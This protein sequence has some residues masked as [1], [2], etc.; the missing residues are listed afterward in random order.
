MNPVQL[1]ALKN[2]RYDTFDELKEH[3]NK[4][5]TVHFCNDRRRWIIE[6]TCSCRVFQRNFICKHLLGLAFYNRLKRCPE[7]GNNKTIAKKKSKGR[8]ALAKKALQK[9]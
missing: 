2:K 7:E 3:R 8:I 1:L 6:S 5:L 9:Q 4:V